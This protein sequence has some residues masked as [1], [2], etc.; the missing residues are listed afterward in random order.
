[1]EKDVSMAF[2]H[3]ETLNS[4]RNARAFHLLPW[5]YEW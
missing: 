5:C 3:G 2:C 4:Q 1:M